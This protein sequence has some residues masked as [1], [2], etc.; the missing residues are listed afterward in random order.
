[1]V[2]EPGSS[3]LMHLRDDAG[4]AQRA[5]DASGLVLH[6]LVVLPHPE[7]RLAIGQGDPHAFPD[8]V[9]VLARER[10]NIGQEG[11]RSLA[12]G[13]NLFVCC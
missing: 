6:A 3:A 1:M 4:M 11:G 5:A 9:R 2:R 7:N 8:R 10:E 12:P 13:L